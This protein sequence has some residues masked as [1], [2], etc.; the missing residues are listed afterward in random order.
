M[1]DILPLSIRIYLLQ[2]SKILPQKAING[3]QKGG[4][5]GKPNTDFLAKT[6][7]HS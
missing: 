6:Q 1:F 7:K 5:P 3:C 2:D 4:L